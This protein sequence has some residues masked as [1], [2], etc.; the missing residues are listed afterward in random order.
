MNR[1]K[2][3]TSLSK[4]SDGFRGAT[5]VRDF[6]WSSPTRLFGTRAFAS[7]GAFARSCCTGNHRFFGYPYSV[8]VAACVAF[9]N[10]DRGG[11]DA[12]LTPIVL[13]NWRT[14]VRQ[15]GKK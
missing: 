15:K 6:D 2:Y 1:L 9:N 5:S 4:W 12:V 13:S 14:P 7:L 10:W 11:V 3:A 8:R